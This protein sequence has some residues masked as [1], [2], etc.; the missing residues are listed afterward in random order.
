MSTATA[1]PVLVPKHSSREG[2]DDDHPLVLPVVEQS[3]GSLTSITSSLSTTT[4]SATAAL[5]RA[6]AGA[7][8][9][10]FKRHIRLFRPVKSALYS[11][12]SVFHV[13]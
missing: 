4:Q 2:D 3:D 5:S 8:A 11:L 12:F 10:M 6:L 13:H 7:L 1:P 9:F